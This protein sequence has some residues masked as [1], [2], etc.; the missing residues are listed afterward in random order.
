MR[1]PA[2]M[3]LL[4]ERA[5]PALVEMSRWKTLAHALPAFILT[6]RLTD[7]TDAQIQDAWSRGDRESVIAAAM[8]NNSKRSDSDPPQRRE[9]D[10]LIGSGVMIYVKSVLAGVAAVAILILLIVI[11]CLFLGYT[12]AATG[13]QILAVGRS[14]RRA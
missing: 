10:G 9:F 13:K 5:L 14:W 8:G 4:R 11:P 1:D 3:T 2:T 12:V 6:G 7:L